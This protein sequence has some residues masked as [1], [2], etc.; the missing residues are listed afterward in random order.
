MGFGPGN[1]LDY[2]A[3][4]AFACLLGYRDR[5]LDLVLVQSTS[6]VFLAY[7]NIGLVGCCNDIGV[8][9]MYVI[10]LA[11]DVPGF[12]W[13]RSSTFGAFLLHI[14]YLYALLGYLYVL[15]S[16]GDTPYAPGSLDALRSSGLLAEQPAGCPIVP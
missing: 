6:Q 3:Y 12:M 15:L 14:A 5:Y 2:P 4:W 10:Y 11:Y 13:L 16:H 8:A 7:P 1:N 9:R